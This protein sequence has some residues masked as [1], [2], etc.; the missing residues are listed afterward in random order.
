MRFLELLE[1]PEKES[2]FRPT[3]GA[4]KGGILGE[5]ERNRRLA[6]HLLRHAETFL[7]REEKFLR[8]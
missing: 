1:C 7:R 8:L 2:I 3:A 5:A 4:E 6:E